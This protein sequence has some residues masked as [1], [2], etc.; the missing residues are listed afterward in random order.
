MTGRIFALA[1]TLVVAMTACA[2][3]SH[4]EPTT[5]SAPTTTQ[6]PG[7]YRLELGVRS[8]EIEY[9]LLDDATAS[10]ADN[11]RTLVESAEE[12]IG[13]YA[14]GHLES[15]TIV[16][17]AD[18]AKLAQVLADD[19]GEDDPQVILENLQTHHFITLGPFVYLDLSAGLQA[20]SYDLVAVGVATAFQ[21]SLLGSLGSSADLA[22]CAR[23]DPAN[24]F[25]GPVWL[26]L[27]VPDYLRT[28]AYFDSG[29][30][31]RV[32]GTS[33]EEG[34]AQIIAAGY[35]GTSLP[36]ADLGFLDTWLDSPNGQALYDLSYAAISLLV[37]QA[38]MRS[39]F[40]YWKRLGDGE[41]W[42]E[43]FQHTFGIGTADFESLFEAQRPPA[44]A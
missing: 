11:L 2:N 10:Q 31:Q 30:W 4:I 36:L 21:Q 1:F 32:H 5:T 41:C 20:D 37:E 19:V 42:D 12:L 29:Y 14:G 27:G 35:A 16:A 9:R 28:Q 17:G 24:E 26:Y 33:P 3:D 23:L 40:E 8:P 13:G 43:A 34:Q 18:A 6:Q 7:A 38:G 44:A 39:L 15:L 22:E 25:A